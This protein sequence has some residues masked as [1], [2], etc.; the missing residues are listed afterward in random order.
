MFFCGKA[1]KSIAFYARSVRICALF[2]Q[3][4]KHNSSAF[5]SAVL[6]AFLM[7]S[8]GF[9]V[10]ESACSAQACSFF[11]FAVGLVLV[12]ALLG[13]QVMRGKGSFSFSWQSAVSGAGISLCILFYFLAIQSISV[14]IAALL[15]YT[16]PVFAVLGEA[17]LNRSLPPRRDGVLILMSVGGIVAVSVFADG[18]TGAGDN[19]AGLLYGLLSGVCYAVY[20][21]LN[22]NIPEQVS[23]VQ[24]TFWQFVAGCALLAVPLLTAEGAFAGV[25]QGWPYLLCIGVLQG[26]VVMLLIAYAVRHLTAIQFGTISYLE[27][28]VAVMLGWLIYAELL[29]PGQWCGFVLVIAASAAQS[30]LPSSDKQS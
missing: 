4:N 25:A 21:L 24:R 13:W 27:P 7:G 14:G 5:L 2:C 18:G 16:G 8:L 22:R 10:R 12:S 3:M 1:H 17:L 15:L 26:F 19:A 28:A 29:S 20:I 9:F 6:A 23:L 11:R 30:L